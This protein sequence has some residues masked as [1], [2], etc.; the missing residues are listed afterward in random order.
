MWN[1]SNSE[2]EDTVSLVEWMRLPSC[3]SH[4]SSVYCLFIWNQEWRKIHH[5]PSESI[6]SHSNE[7]W[8]L[9]GPLYSSASSKRCRSIYSA[10]FCRTFSTDILSPCCSSKVTYLLNR[11]FIFFVERFNVMT[12]S[13][14]F[15]GW[16][17][18]HLVIIKIIGDNELLIMSRSWI[19]LM[20]SK[21]LD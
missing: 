12:R 21:F 19:I 7:I 13:K 8:P 20:L 4:L 17:M 16:Q 15:L 11:N 9:L 6:D 2:V 5:F 18:V 14:I 3:L 1:V 10:A